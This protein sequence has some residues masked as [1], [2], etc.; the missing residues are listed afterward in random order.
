MGSPV[1]SAHK[2]SV[3]LIEV[4]TSV[5]AVSSKAGTQM[6]LTTSSPGEIL[7]GSQLAASFRGLLE[8]GTEVS[9][10]PCPL[11]KRGV[12]PG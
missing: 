11:L 9:Q 1:Y 4:G 6:V 7:R 3:M 8:N 10:K 2:T 12:W 5:A